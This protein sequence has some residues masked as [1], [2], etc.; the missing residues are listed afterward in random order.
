MDIFRKITNFKENSASSISNI[1]Y[2]LSYK[3][4]GKV[5]NESCYTYNN[6]KII[7]MRPLIVNTS[8]K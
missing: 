8:I 5:L 2:V 1:Y 3:I 6:N 7:I 4:L